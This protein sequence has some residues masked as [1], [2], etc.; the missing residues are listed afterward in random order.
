MNY[1]SVSAICVLNGYFNRCAPGNNIADHRTASIAHFKQAITHAEESH[2][3]LHNTILRQPAISQE[4][5]MGPTAR[6]EIHRKYVLL[7]FE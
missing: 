7:H 4:F 2:S 6:L 1:P 5:K 3:P